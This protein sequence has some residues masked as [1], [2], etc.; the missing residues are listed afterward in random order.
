MTDS[1][2]KNKVTRSQ[3]KQDVICTNF[4]LSFF[5]VEVIITYRA[6]LLPVYTQGHYLPRA[7]FED[8]LSLICA[9]EHGGKENVR[10]CVCVYSYWL[11]KL[12]FLF[13]TSN[14]LSLTFSRTQQREVFERSSNIPVSENSALNLQ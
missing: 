4:K 1:H 2:P 14:T 13:T 3:Y 9:R 10:V 5:L 7:D 11:V 6:I 12:L 8:I